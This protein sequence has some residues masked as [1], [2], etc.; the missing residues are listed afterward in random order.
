MQNR[1]RTFTYKNRERLSIID[2]NNPSNDISGGS[3]NIEVIQAAFR[4]AYYD[5][6]KQLTALGVAGHA[7]S[8]LCEILEG[9]YSSFREQRTYLR[10][11]H[12]KNHGP[13]SD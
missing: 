6:T 12:E 5:M 13:V 1:V 10:H 9:D 8:V 4:D 7:G 2:P 11:L 3:S